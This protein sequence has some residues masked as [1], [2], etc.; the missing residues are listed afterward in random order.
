MFDKRAYIIDETDQDNEDAAVMSGAVLYRIASLS[1]WGKD[2]VLSGA[3]A[4]RGSSD[5]RFHRINQLT[6]YCANNVIV[7]L[8]ELL[9]HMYRKVLDGIRD[10]QHPRHI[11]S[12]ASADYRLVILSVDEINELV[13]AD[14]EGARILYDPRVAGSTVIFPDPTYGPLHDFSDQLRRGSKNGVVYPS[15]RH[16][17]DFAFAFFK[18][19]TSKIRSDFYEAISLNLQLVPE[20]QD[21]T[22]P[23][24][25]CKPIVQ[26]LHATMGFYKFTDAT[27]LTD[28]KGR[29]LVNPANIPEQ[30]YIDFVR[31]NY[32][33][34][35]NDA[36][37]P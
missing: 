1:H 35:P 27:T 12:W 18:D 29:G 23:P 17:V 2:D 15:A 25:K 9:Y 14:S 10:R 36:V 16:S 26:K 30:G 4:A 7:C 33:S 21:L 20:S 13:Y 8:A 34:Y 3:G 31:R 32:R 28:V 37:L 22:S 6:S 24:I 5:G 11:N 19:E